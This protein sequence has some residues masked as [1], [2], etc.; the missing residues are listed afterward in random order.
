MNDYTAAAIVNIGQRLSAELGIAVRRDADAG[1][2]PG[3]SESS[4]DARAELCRR[5]SEVPLVRMTGFAQ[6][7]QGAFGQD[8]ASRANLGDIQDGVGFR[9]ARLQAVGNLSEF[10]RYSIEMDFAVAGRPSFMDVWGE[11]TNV[12]LFGNVRIGQFRQPTT[13]D[14][15]TNIRHLE[16]LERSLPFQGA[17][18]FPPRRHHELVQRGRGRPNA[19]RL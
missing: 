7:D 1:K 16:F 12:P 5:Q 11:Q 3:H 18:S 2:L 19:D 10:T 4:F 13:M 9:R 8:A 6:L 15:W 14:G 17:G